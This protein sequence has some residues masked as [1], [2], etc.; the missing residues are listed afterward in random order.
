MHMNTNKYKE[1]EKGGNYNWYTK[2]DG[3]IY[4]SLCLHDTDKS[5]NDVWENNLH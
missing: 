5:L 2:S 1:E 4:S 3:I